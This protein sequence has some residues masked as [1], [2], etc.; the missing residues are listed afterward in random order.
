MTS[1]VRNRNHVPKHHCNA[2]HK[3]APKMLDLPHSF[4][5]FDFVLCSSLFTLRFS[6]FALC[7]FSLT[8]K[9]S[10]VL[11]H[12]FTSTQHRHLHTTR[13]SISSVECFFRSSFLSFECPG[14]FCAASCAVR[15]S[16]SSS[17]SHDRM[18]I[19][20]IVTVGPS[21]LSRSL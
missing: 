7:F 2:K 5:A 18:L 6:L 1:L 15:P 16:K 4:Q 14:A 9:P 8:F 12:T 21:R 13:L 20:I 19:G 11:R 3:Y 10:P 17:I